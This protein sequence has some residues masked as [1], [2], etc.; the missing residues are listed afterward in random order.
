MTTLNRRP[1]LVQEVRQLNRQII[2][3]GILNALHIRPTLEDRIKKAQDKDEEIQ[4]F[5]QQSSKKELIGFRINEQGK[6]WYED[7]ICVPKDEALRRLILDEAHHSTYSIH[8]G[9]TKMYMDLKQR[10]WWTGMK[11]DIAEY[12]TQCDTC[13]LVKAEHQWPVGLLQPLHIPV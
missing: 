12:V 3:Q 8:P 4:Y 5:K 7:R 13:R 9:S 2:P 1:K 11:G 10:Y 6:L